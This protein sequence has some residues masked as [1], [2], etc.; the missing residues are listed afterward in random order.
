MKKVLC[1]G[2]AFAF[3]LT[4][5]VPAYAGVDK[6]KDGFVKVVKSP[7]QLIERPK[8]GM[9][10]MDSRPVG[11]LKGLVESPF[12]MLKDIGGGLIDVVT[13]PFE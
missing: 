12:Y 1:L 10:E 9:D 13:F 3:V 11:F 2:I 7:M 5:S 4:L 8:M 6:L